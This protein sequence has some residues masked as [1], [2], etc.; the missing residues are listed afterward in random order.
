MNVG[1]L[2]RERLKGILESIRSVRAAVIGDIC[3]DAYW[4]A[5][6]TKS[7]LSRETPHFPYPI[8]RE[9]MSPGAG[10]NVACNLAALKPRSVRLLSVIGRD[11]R[12]DMLVQSLEDRAV[13]TRLM[14]RDPERV[15]GAYIKPMLKGTSDTVY[16]APRLDFENTLPLSPASEDALIRSLEEIAAECDV[17]CVCDQMSNGC[18]TPRVIEKLNAI[19]AQGR[20][21]IA[22]SRER[23]TRF[24][25]VIVKPNDLE[26]RV[27]VGLD[28]SIAEAALKL[29]ALTGGL[30]VVTTGEDG[31]LVSDG[32]SVCPVATR[33]ATP[34]IDIVGAGDAFLSAFA[35]CF[36]AGADAT[37]AA[38]VANLASYVTIHKIGTTGTASPEEILAAL[39]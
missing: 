29:S 13:D 34:P 8:V 38:Q 31:C 17:I 21:V 9:A 12:G 1:H 10:G 36:A 27:A 2:D 37:E 7:R 14:I 35:C 30:S 25:H 15:T 20:I 26:L 33:P 18:V 22:D 39:S 3:L 23:I 32:E 19:G 11:W 5:D 24:R 28:G 4:Y 16:E 6:M